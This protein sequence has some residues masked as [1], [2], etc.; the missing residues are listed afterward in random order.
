M[1][2]GRRRE[3]VIGKGERESSLFVYACVCFEYSVYVC[4]DVFDIA[5]RRGERN[6]RIMNHRIGRIVV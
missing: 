5:R 1:S 4:F 3:K 2:V 6:E